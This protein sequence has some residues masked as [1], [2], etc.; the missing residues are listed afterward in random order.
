MTKKIIL[1]WQ[2][3]FINLPKTLNLNSYVLRLLKIRIFKLE[4][5]KKKFANRIFPPLIDAH[6][7][8]IQGTG[9]LFLLSKI[10]CKGYMMLQKNP[11]GNAQFFKIHLIFYHF[12]LF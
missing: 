8:K 2:Q 1:F 10:L 9:I 5:K 4:Q 6:G 3:E 7:F 12:F 11:I